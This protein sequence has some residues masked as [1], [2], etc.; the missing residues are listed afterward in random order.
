V[1]I[2]VN[3]YVWGDLKP[4]NQCIKYLFDSRPEV[5]WPNKLS[6]MFLRAP[7][8]TI[9][10]V[11]YF[12][13]AFTVFCLFKIIPVVANPE[14]ALPSPQTQVILNS[15]HIVTT[16]LLCMAWSSKWFLSMKPSYQ[17]LC[18]LTRDAPLS[19]I[20]VRRSSVCLN[21]I[22]LLQSV[23]ERTSRQPPSAKCLLCS[24]FCEFWRVWY[25]L[26]PSGTLF[27]ILI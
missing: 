25:H 8:L 5:D 27:S 2:V 13:W 10:L 9:I 19:V 16:L 18:I 22:L 4:V 24:Q 17:V 6:M 11:Q 15:N 26:V 21:W 3:H 14:F 20:H 7:S 12:D 1:L 23:Y